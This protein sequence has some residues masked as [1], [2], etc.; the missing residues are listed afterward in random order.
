MI[1]EYRV[2]DGI[3]IGKWEPNY[4]DKTWR[5]S[6]FYT[7]NRKQINLGSN[8]GHA[9]WNQ[10][11]NRLSHVIIREYVFVDIRGVYNKAPW[12][13]NKYATQHHSN[14]KNYYRSMWAPL[15]HPNGGPWDSLII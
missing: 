13:I 6:T 7:I 5:S 4:P 10:E 3:T 1:K 2:V 15:M 8:P 12:V 11:T 9:V 14:F